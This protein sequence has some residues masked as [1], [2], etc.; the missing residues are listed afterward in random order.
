LGPSGDDLVG[1]QINRFRSVAVLAATAALGVG[2]L[3]PVA[4]ARHG[5]DDP[6]S[7]DRGDDHGGRVRARVSRHG[8]DD[9]AEHARGDDRG[10]RH[11][12]EDRA[13]AARHGGD[14]RGRHAG[15]G[16]DDPAGHH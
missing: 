2:G 15:Q 10:R 4:L 12:A 14:D 1:M 11:G 7:H 16:A 8:A 9:P 5:A 6:A 3:A 13:R